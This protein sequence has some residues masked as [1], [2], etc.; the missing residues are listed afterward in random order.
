MAE[1]RAAPA[2]WREASSVARL[3]CRAVGGSSP[4]HMEPYY[5]QPGFGGTL[6]WQGGGAEADKLG[7]RGVWQA[8]RQAA[9]G[10]VILPW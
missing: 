10:L 5:F 3:G 4:T 8:G 2:R 9:D 7:S 1:S 6:D